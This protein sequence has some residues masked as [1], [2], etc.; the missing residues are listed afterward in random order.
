MR[1]GVNKVII[2]GHVGNEP[3]QRFTQNNTK[4]VTLSL[5]TSEQWKDQQTNEPQSRTEW[6]RVVFFGRLAE[7]VGDYVHKGRQIYIE[8]RLQTR[9]WQDQRTGQD[10]Y[11]TEIIANQLQLIGGRDSDHRSSRQDSFDRSGGDYY[12]PSYNQEDSHRSEPAAQ[13]Q[14]SSPAGQDIDDIPW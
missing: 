2:L 8:G 9:K 10:R 12:E 1:K 14:D 7:I 6:H 3:E 4:V 5:A 13:Q 11:S